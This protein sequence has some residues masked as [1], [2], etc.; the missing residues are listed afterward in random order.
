[1]LGTLKN[2]E[3][4]REPPSSTCR[5]GHLCHVLGLFGGSRVD[6]TREPYSLMHISVCTCKTQNHITIPVP[7][8]VHNSSYH[9]MPSLVSVFPHCLWSVFTLCCSIRIQT[10]AIYCVWWVCFLNSFML[11]SFLSPPPNFFFIPF[12][13]W[14]SWWISRSFFFLISVF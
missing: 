8:T 12:N 14:R 1:M 10:R 7:D 9:W 6:P 4:H 2:R 11:L 5:H 3:Q 13:Y